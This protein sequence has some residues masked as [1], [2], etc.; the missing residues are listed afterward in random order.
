MVK[1]VRGVRLEKEGEGME[2]RGRL[3][4]ERDREWETHVEGG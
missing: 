3:A 4:G 2:G 1:G